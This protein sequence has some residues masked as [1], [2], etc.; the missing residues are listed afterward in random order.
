MSFEA[1]AFIVELAAAIEAAGLDVVVVGAGAAVLR[2]AP[3][4]TR[5]I[6]LLLRDTALNRKK[7][8]RLAQILGGS[9]PAPLLELTNA[10]R[11]FSPERP[12]VDLLF[13]RL[14]GGL[15]FAVVRSRSD[16]IDLGGARLRVAALAHVIRSKQAAG[17]PKDLAMLPILRDTLATLKAAGRK[18]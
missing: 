15:T 13:D 7:L 1:E 3:L 11:I 9:K 4:V 6:D 14:P 8:E 17:R 2:G 12:P 18:S 5:D 16:W 10:E